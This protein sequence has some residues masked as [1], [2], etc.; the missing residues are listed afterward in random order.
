MEINRTFDMLDQIGEKY[1]NKADMLAAR[2][3]GNWK[4]YSSGEYVK[5]AYA[6]A[7]GLMA[8]G[9][10]RGDKIVTIS[11]NRPEWNFFDMGMAMAGI[12]QVPVYPTISAEEYAYILDHAAPRLVVL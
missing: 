4:K 6:I 10:K 12:I 8:M 11:N 5:T 1:G 2:T 9:L 3:N 7:Y